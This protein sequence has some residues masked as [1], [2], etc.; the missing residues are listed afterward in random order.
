MKF[1]E[2]RGSAVEMGRQYGEAARSEIRYAEELWTPFFKK[3]PQR[4]YF[5][6]EACAALER[7]A[8]MCFLNSKGWQTVLGWHFLLSLPSIVWTHSVRKWNG[9]LL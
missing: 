9:V 1:V 5:M 6:Q 8:R 7:Y 4:P 3:Y 2:C